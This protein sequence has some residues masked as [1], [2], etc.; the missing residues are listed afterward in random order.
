MLRQS[1]LGYQILKTLKLDKSRFEK[2]LLLNRFDFVYFLSP[3]PSALA[4]LNIPMLNTVWDLGHR[5]YPEFEEFSL[6]G[7]FQK[8]EYFYNHVLA[9]SS[10]VI[11]DGE[12][13]KAELVAFYGVQA[14]RITPLGLFPQPYQH[15]CGLTCLKEQF[16]F[17]PAQ[18]W[19]HKNH[20]VLV[21]SFELIK[22][23]YPNLKLVFSGADKGSMK[24]IKNLVDKLGLNQTVLFVGFVSAEEMAMYYHHASVTAFPSKLG[25]TNLPPLESLLSGTPV[26]VSDVHEFDFALPVGGYTKVPTTESV[27]W[28]RAITEKLEDGTKELELA[29]ATAK[30]LDAN[31][32]KVD[33]KRLFDV[34][35]MN[36]KE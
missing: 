23:K 21:K 12:K 13:T 28:A 10:H 36:V 3:N 14:S 11:V 27:L 26:I 35:V 2:F 33:F 8:R 15:M 17:Y 31:S 34:K 18:F 20:E 24:K 29:A 19:E 1:A 7:K 16:V 5:H 4:I 6:G 32:S 25:Y 9:R 22:P 30:I